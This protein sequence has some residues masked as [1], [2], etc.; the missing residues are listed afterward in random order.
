MYSGAGPVKS[1]GQL[2]GEPAKAGFFWT[3]VTRCLLQ[4]AGIDLSS[5][6]LC[7]PHAAASQPLQWEDSEAEP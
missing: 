6:Q 7:G 3:P 2:W 5:Q 1:G 4:K